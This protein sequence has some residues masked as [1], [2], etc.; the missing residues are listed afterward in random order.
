MPNTIDLEFGD[1]VY[2]F[3]LPLPQIAELQRKCGIGIGGSSPGLKGCHVHPTGEVHIDAKLGEFYALDIIETVRHGLIGGGKGIVN[4]EEV[5]VTPLIAN[6]LVETY[7]LGK[8]LKRKL[9]H[10]RSDPRRLHRGIRSAKK[11]RAPA[12][13]GAAKD[14]G[15]LDYGLALINCRM[16]GIVARGSD[17]LSLHE[18]EALL[19]HWNE[20]HDTSVAMS[21]LQILRIAMP[22]LDRI[23]ADP[24]LTH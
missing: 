5:K 3:A 16:M 24:L 1:G 17:S 19:Y 20:A 9:E 14:D 11:R 12:R 18:Y 13:A 8:P 23:N 2:T 22:L 21:R 4:G 10:R 6:K 7:V 15:Y